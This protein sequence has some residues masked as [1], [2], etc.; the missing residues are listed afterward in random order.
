MVLYRLD[1]GADTNR[2]CNN[3][4]GNSDSAVI[5]RDI[6]S[7]RPRVGPGCVLCTRI[8]PLLTKLKRHGTM[9]Y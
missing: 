5:H 4:E 6:T 3:M 9:M 7:W 8:D 2:H 1:G